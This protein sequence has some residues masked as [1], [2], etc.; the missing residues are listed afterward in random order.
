MCSMC[1]WFHSDTTLYLLACAEERLLFVQESAVSDCLMD[2]SEAVIGRANT[3][4]AHHSIRLCK[5]SSD[6]L[7]H[8]KRRC[9]PDNSVKRCKRVGQVVNSRPV[10]DG[11]EWSDA[12]LDHYVN[13]DVGKTADSLFSKLG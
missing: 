2:L 10:D 12:E 9:L 5:G 3:L 13:S 8:Q 7:P 1:R 4:P 11:D 6:L